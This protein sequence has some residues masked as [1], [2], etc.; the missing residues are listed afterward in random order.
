M[1]TTRVLTC[2]AADRPSD[3]LRHGPHPIQLLTL[4]NDNSMVGVGDRP[5]SRFFFAAALGRANL[6]A[7]NATVYPYLPRALPTD[8]LWPTCAGNQV[9]CYAPVPQQ[10]VRQPQ[11]PA[12]LCAMRFRD[13]STMTYG[14]L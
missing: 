9:V 1:H 7:P 14:T 10:Q 8:W 11:Q 5:C 3:C 6:D 4:G 12:G 13:G 2:G